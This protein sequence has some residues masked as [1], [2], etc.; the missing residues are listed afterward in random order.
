MKL[1]K[2]TAAIAATAAVATAQAATISGGGLNGVATDADTAAAVS[3]VAIVA[4]T[5]LVDGL[6]AMQGFDAAC[7]G[8]VSM[9]CAPSISS[10]ELRSILNNSIINTANVVG[11]GT[12]LGA[13]SGLAGKSGS[14][15][16]YAAEGVT[17]ALNAFN[18]SGSIN[19]LSCG[20]SAP[21]QISNVTANDAATLAGAAAGA[22]FGFVHATELDGSLGFIK[23]DGVAP[24]ALSL[25]SSNYNLV[26]NLSADG[27]VADSSV[28]GTTVGVV[29]GGAGVA[30]HAPFACSGLNPGAIAGDTNGG[31][32]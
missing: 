5:Q 16:E 14:I 18:G 10:A 32:I 21:V 12:T 1:L 27:G 4:S 31:S 7:T 20:Q 28:N 13:A 9:L 29:A 17:D 26:S 6:R 3:A 22:S 15:K 30:S 11:G 8:N 24:N 2:I 19:G 25:A 23:L